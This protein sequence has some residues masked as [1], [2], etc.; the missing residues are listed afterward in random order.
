MKIRKKYKYINLTRFND[1]TFN[2]FM[3]SLNLK[4]QTNSIMNINNIMTYTYK[5]LMI[6]KG[7]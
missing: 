7:S 1:I 5:N 2:D 4:I 6:E 3:E